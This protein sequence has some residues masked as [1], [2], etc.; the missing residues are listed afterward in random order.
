MRNSTKRKLNTV[1]NTGLVCTPVGFIAG[2]SYDHVADG[3]FAVLSHLAM[4][5]GNVLG[6]LV[7]AWCVLQLI[8]GIVHG[9]RQG[10]KER[11]NVQ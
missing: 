10:W 1:R 9:I 3:W 11:N 2:M 4:Q 5:A 7:A 6:F 8:I